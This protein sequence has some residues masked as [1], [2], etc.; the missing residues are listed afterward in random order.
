ME[1]EEEFHYEDGNQ[2]LDEV[3]RRDNIL[4]EHD[5]HGHIDSSSG[6]VKELEALQ[7]TIA[8]KNTFL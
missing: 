3:W 2:N 1:V 6:Y 5:I 4:I 7:I 8:K